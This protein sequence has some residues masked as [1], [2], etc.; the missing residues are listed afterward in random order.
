[1]VQLITRAAACASATASACKRGQL[2]GKEF[3][4]AA[5]SYL[6]C[7]MRPKAATPRELEADYD[8]RLLPLSDSDAEGQLDCESESESK[9]AIAQ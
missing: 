1:M 6:L 5:L 8:W 9:P 4:P 3:L 2:E 7:G